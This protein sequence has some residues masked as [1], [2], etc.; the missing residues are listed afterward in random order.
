LFFKKSLEDRVEKAKNDNNELNILIEEYKPF[1]ASTIQKKTGKYVRYGYD[2]ELTIGMMA[3]K[4][5]IDSYD[6]NKG[7][8]LSFAKQVISLRMIDFYRKN[9]DNNIVY[10]SSYEG[11][12]EEG[13]IDF[14]A[15][16]AIDD[17]NTKEEN[18]IRKMEILEYKKELQEWGIEFSDLVN[19][20]PKQ[21]KVRELYKKIALLIA[22]NDDLYNDLYRT[23]RLPIKEIQSQTD[24]HRKKLER[25]R[26]YII[27]LVVVIKGQYEHLNEYLKWR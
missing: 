1:I 15:S 22:N 20:S 7:K 26:I 10:L 18:E 25:G 27:S 2:D 23:K 16:K 17:Y 4:E 24:I 12:E 8:F 5:A 3:F 13:Y 11:D 14:T 6:R 9:K 19:N 21:E